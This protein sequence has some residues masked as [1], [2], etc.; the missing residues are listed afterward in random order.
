LLGFRVPG[1]PASITEA[2]L[3]AW[4]EEGVID[5]LGPAADVRPMVAEADCVVLPSA[6]REGVPRSLLEAGAMGKPL[7]TT[8]AIGCREAVED[9]VTGILCTRGSAPA[10][11]EAMQR[12]IDLGPEGRKAFGERGRARMELLFDDRIVHNSYRKALRGAGV[13]PES[14]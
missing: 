2:E 12:M 1:D 7:I 6:Y 11:A 3:K 5:Y 4:Q 9:G 10:L 13:I 8:D 14:V